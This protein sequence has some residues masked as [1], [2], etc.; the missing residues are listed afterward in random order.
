MTRAGEHARRKATSE[1]ASREKSAG[2]RAAASSRSARRTR[3]H[4]EGIAHRTLTWR[5]RYLA[6]RRRVTE[7]FVG[8]FEERCSYI[9]RS[10]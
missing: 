8:I 2:E 7:T 4:E 1:F 10:V 9:T 6:W 5:H 3:R